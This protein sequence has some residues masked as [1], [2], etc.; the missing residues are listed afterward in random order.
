MKFPAIFQTDIATEPSCIFEVLFAIK[1]HLTVISTNI[2]TYNNNKNNAAKTPT[3]IIITP[4]KQTAKQRSPPQNQSNDA[5]HAR[6]NVVLSMSESISCDSS[7]FDHY[8]N[9]PQTY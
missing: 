1:I 8:A 3:L 5:V 2:V 9:T 7:E 6:T 4:S